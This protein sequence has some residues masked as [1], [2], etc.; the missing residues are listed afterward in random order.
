MGEPVERL[1]T[2]FSKRYPNAQIVEKS[3][4]FTLKTS[5]TVLSQQPD[6][7]VKLDRNQRLML[8]V[9]APGAAWIWRGGSLLLIMGTGL[10]WVRFRSGGPTASAHDPAGTPPADAPSTADASQDLSDIQIR[11][12]KDFG[13]QHVQTEDQ[14]LESSAATPALQLRILADFGTQSLQILDDKESKHD[15]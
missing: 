10:A 2:A 1:R 9:A 3:S 15:E 14:D 7:G 12:I 8:A 4:Y 13:T 5:G 6:A 11:V